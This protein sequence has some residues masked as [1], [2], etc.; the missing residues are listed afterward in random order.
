ELDAVTRA[1]EVAAGQLLHLAHPVA[2]RVAVTEQPPRRGLPLAVALDERLERAHELAA[3]VALVGLDRAERRL[4]EQAQRVGV[5]QR[6]QQREG[7]EVAVGGERAGRVAVR[8]PGGAEHAGLQGAA[9]LVERLPRASCR[10]GT[11]GARG[12]RSG[13][14]LLHDTREDAL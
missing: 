4:A 3:V 8:G 1:R 10:G 14:G 13:A 11:T 6:Q 2:Q 5:L 9:R 12:Q 7:S